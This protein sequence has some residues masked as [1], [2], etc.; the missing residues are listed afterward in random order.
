MELLGVSV[1]PSAGWCENQSINSWHSYWAPDT[2]MKR[3]HLCSVF[4]TT[5]KC[6][7]ALS[8]VWMLPSARDIHHLDALVFKNLA[9]IF[10]HPIHFYCTPTRCQVLTDEALQIEQWTRQMTSLHSWNW[11]SI[12][13]YEEN[14]WRVDVRKGLSKEG[15]SEFSMR[16]CQP[17]QDLAERGSQ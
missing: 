5:F 6:L 7:V 16:R 2:I 10:L 15:T 11:Q 4:L 8:G 13:G 9:V 12:G 1:K 3:A 14:Q 17:L